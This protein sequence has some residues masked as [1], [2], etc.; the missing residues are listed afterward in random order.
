MWLS[1]ILRLGPLGFRLEGRYNLQGQY[2]ALEHMQIS[3]HPRHL[4]C[5]NVNIIEYVCGAAVTQSP[6]T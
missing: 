4:C 2:F 1:I 6:K 5:H 3:A